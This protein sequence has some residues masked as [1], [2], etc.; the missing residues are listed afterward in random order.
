MQKSTLHK[1]NPVFKLQALSFHARGMTFVEVIVASAIFL[2]ISVSLYQAFVSLFQVTSTSRVKLSAA[3][4]ASEQFEIARNM[5]YSKV[6]V[7]GSIP[8]GV[9]PHVQT[10]LRDGYAFTATTTVRNGDDPFDGT[11]G[12]TPND[13]SP[14]DYKLVEVEIGCSTCREFAPV[15]FTTRV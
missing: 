7:V 5:P 14:A 1:R 9:I 11:I 3:S 15:T 4:L 10:L 6:G 13:L 2:M 12:G 8:V